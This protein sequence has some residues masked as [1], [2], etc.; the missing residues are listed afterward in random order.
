MKNILKPKF[1]IGF[2]FS[3]IGLYV[4]FKDFNFISFIASIKKT[5]LFYVILASALLIVSVW[6]RAI[7]WHCLLSKEKKIGYKSLFEIEMLGFFGN[8]ILPLRLGELYRSI[9]LS[10][11]FKLPKSTVIGSIVLERMLDTIGLIF[12]ASFLLFYPIENEI[13]NY[14]I[15]GIVLIIFIGIILFLYIYLYLVLYIQE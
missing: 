2:I 7:R 13:K 6:F 9:V 14:I 12:F 5:N 3:F 15:F 1:F 11:Q 8:N 4:A 10:K